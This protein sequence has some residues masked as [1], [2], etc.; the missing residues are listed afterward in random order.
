MI[1]AL[2]QIQ[3]QSYVYFSNYMQFMSIFSLFLKN[4]NLFLTNFHTNFSRGI[5]RWM[6]RLGWR[7]KR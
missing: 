2:I 6:M 1:E 7:I 4:Y 3:M 5:P